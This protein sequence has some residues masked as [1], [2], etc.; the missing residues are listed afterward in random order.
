MSKRFLVVLRL[1][2]RK[3]T[4]FIRKHYQIYSQQRLFIKYFLTKPRL[5]RREIET[6]Y[7][8]ISIYIHVQWNKTITQSIYMYKQFLAGGVLLN[9]RWIQHGF[10]SPSWLHFQAE[11]ELYNK[12]HVKRWSNITCRHK[13]IILMLVDVQFAV[14]D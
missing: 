6:Y 3:H 10:D 1:C 5:K 13:I 8:Q 7:S 14:A 9:F 12:H 2:Y 11:N 4:Y